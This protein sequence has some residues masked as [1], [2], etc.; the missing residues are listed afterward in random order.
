MYPLGVVCKHSFGILYF[1]TRL[2]RKEAELN[3]LY[4]Y[5]TAALRSNDVMWLSKNRQKIDTLEK[6][7]I[8]LRRNNVTS[9]QEL[10]RGKD[11]E[12]KN[13]FYVGMLRISMLA[14]VVNEA[15]EE[16]GALM[17]SEFNVAD[18]SLKNEVK[19]LS[20]MSRRIASFVC[21]T[22]S[23]ILQDCIVD[24]DKFVDNCI[25]LATKHITSKLKIKTKI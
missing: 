15:C 6:E 19:D 11:E 1:M 2:E 5:R 10:L 3:K 18:F 14:D 25:K 12:T 16:I 24:N 9:L 17:K 13:R 23:P 7:V 8:A 4:E 21:N 20:T 22:G